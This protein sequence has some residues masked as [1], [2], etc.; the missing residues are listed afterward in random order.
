[1]PPACI[2]RECMSLARDLISVFAFQKVDFMSSIGLISHGKRRG[3]FEKMISLIM[4]HIAVDVPKSV[5]I[6]CRLF[7]LIREAE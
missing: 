6:D 7:I 1:M 3:M 5:Y 2:T 4:I